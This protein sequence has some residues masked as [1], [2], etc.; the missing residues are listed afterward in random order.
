[1]AV[2]QTIFLVQVHIELSTVNLHSHRDSIW[3][4]DIKKNV[5]IPIDR[6]TELTVRKD[7]E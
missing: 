6:V 3:N 2:M 5:P 4:Y 1:M 7:H